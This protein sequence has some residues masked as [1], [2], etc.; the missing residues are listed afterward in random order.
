VVKYCSVGTNLSNGKAKQV[1]KK[2]ARLA[3]GFFRNFG[4]ASATL[5]VRQWL[6]IAVKTKKIKMRT[7]GHGAL[8]RDKFNQCRFITRSQANGNGGGQKCGIPA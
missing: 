8:P 4:D 7:D 2:T 6:E 1:Q 5:S 3:G